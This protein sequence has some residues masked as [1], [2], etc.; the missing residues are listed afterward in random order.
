MNAG[1]EQAEQM[2]QINPVSIYEIGN[3]IFKIQLRIQ[4]IFMTKVLPKI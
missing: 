2:L 4:D 3:R 1:H